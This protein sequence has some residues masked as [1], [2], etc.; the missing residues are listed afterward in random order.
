MNSCRF[1]SKQI[2][3]NFVTFVGWARF[4]VPT[5]PLRRWATLRR[6]SDCGQ[7][8]S[9]FAHPANARQLFYFFN[10]IGII[11]RFCYISVRSNRQSPWQYSHHRVPWRCKDNLASFI[12]QLTLCCETILQ[13][14]LNNLQNC[15][16]GRKK[17]EPL[18][19]F[20]EGCR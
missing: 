15:L 11:K 7:R 6:G 20:Y 2:V 4:F 3:R 9:A 18:S 17:C 8:G 12:C 19:S 13:I 5:V 16:T 14:V 10:N 1:A